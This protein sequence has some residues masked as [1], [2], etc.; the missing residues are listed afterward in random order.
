MDFKIIGPTGNLVGLAETACDA[1][2]KLRAGLVGLHL[3]LDD[4]GIEISGADLDVLCAAEE[5]HA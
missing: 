1:R 4:T 2:T 3:L 5:F